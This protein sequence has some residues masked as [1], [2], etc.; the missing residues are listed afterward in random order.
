MN[1]SEILITVLCNPL[2]EQLSMGCD[3]IFKQCDVKNLIRQ[4]HDRGSQITWEAVQTCLGSLDSHHTVTSAL[5]TLDESVDSAIRAIKDNILGMPKI[6]STSMSDLSPERDPLLS[7]GIDPA[8]IDTTL[9][10]NGEGKVIKGLVYKGGEIQ[11]DD[12]FQNIVPTDKYR[13][14]YNAGSYFYSDK[15]HGRAS[16]VDTYGLEDPEATLTELK[17]YLSQEIAKNLYL[18]GVGATCQVGP[19]LEYDSNVHINHNQFSLLSTSAEAKDNQIPGRLAT[20]FATDPHHDKARLTYLRAVSGVGFEET[21]PLT[22]FR[23]AFEKIDQFRR[24]GKVLISCSEGVSRSATLM[25]A[26]L[27]YRGGLSLQQALCHIQQQRVII[28]PKPQMLK[29]LHDYETALI[30]KRGGVP[31]GVVVPEA[32]VLAAAGGTQPHVVEMPRGIEGGAIAKTLTSYPEST[33]RDALGKL[34]EWAGLGS[35]PAGGPCVYD[36]SIHRLFHEVNRA[37]GIGFK[38]LIFNELYKGTGVDTTKPKILYVAPVA[39]DAGKLKDAFQQAW[40][41]LIVRKK[42]SPRS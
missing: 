36:Q 39:L 40:D 13:N 1:P 26:Y 27:M 29:I 9:E 42:E 38:E 8:S 34:A 25:T 16:F 28:A 17:P 2:V 30:K 32:S 24:A 3:L 41:Q 22:W 14:Q 37:F 15:R 18:G 4:I 5:P 7:L 12:S 11:Y 10:R 35:K 33:G 19:G 31:E 20:F 23:E 21:Q 6:L